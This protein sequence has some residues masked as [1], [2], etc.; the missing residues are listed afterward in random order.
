MSKLDECCVFILSYDRPERVKTLKT[1]ENHGYTGDWKIIVDHEDDYE[2]YS[3]EHGEDSVIF[4]NKDDALP[5]LDRANNFNNRNCNVYA[6]YLSFELAEELGYKY[7]LMLDDDYE[8]FQFRFNERLEYACNKVEDLDRYL[9]LA[10]EY[11]DDAKLDTLCV[12]QGG[13]F[14]GGQHS[15][16][17]E[18]V[19]TKRKAMNT[20]LCSTERQFD[21][22]GTINEDVN[23][24][25]R[26]AQLGKIFLTTN[27]FSVEQEDT[28]Q[29]EGGLTEIYLDEGTYIKS[30]YTILYAPSCTSL[31]NL[32][33]RAEPRIHHNVSWRNAVP[34]IIPEE[35]KK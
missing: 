25:V 3:E 10:I 6:R 26:A 22:R 17:A 20:F 9:E 30:F 16:F 12:A 35:Y 7:F 4:L 28:Q 23:T 27:V 13:D 34:K 5:D 29:D 24:Y 1:L 15:S 11:L 31:M 14:I 2:S 32:H 8:Y 18:A 21:F 33:D 19:D